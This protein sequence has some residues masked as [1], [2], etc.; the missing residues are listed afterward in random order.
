MGLGR[1]IFKD[2]RLLGPIR[3][4]EIVYVNGGMDLSAIDVQ[5]GQRMTRPG[6]FLVKNSI[7]LC[8]LFQGK[9]VLAKCPEASRTGT[10]KAI[11][12]FTYLSVS[13]LYTFDAIQ[14]IHK[15]QP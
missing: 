8:E 10:L 1:E 9:F 15:P 6:T 4:L 11:F 7:E 2:V 14:H 3:N 5:G 13:A 12:V